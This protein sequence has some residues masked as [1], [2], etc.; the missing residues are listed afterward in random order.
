V[1]THDFAYDGNGNVAALVNSANGTLAGQW[2]YG[3]FG[4]VTRATG[5]MAK[6]NPILFSTKYDDDE[7]GLSYYGYRYYEP[8]TGRWLSRDPIGTTGGINLYYFSANSTANAIDILGEFVEWHHGFPQAIFTPDFLT[9]VGITP[10]KLDI[11]SKEFGHML[12]FSQHRGA[13]DSLHSQKWNQTW[14]DWIKEQQS[15]GIPI[16][17][18]RLKSRLQDMKNMPKFAK[19]YKLGVPAKYD[20]KGWKVVEDKIKREVNKK[21]AKLL[22]KRATKIGSKRIPLIG[23]LPSA[24]FFVDDCRSE[25]FWKASGE[26]VVGAIPYVGTTYGVYQIADV[27]SKK[28][29]LVE[30]EVS[31]RVYTGAY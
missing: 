12:D 2:E 14:S 31:A 17:A 13:V 28:D 1:G 23:L 7:T 6:I 29:E 24:Y 30:E 20:Y 26:A 15:K 19:F 27:Y 4:E 3:P 21:I 5:L 8:S 16:T 25:G 11:N 10:D 22:A 9:S 18:E